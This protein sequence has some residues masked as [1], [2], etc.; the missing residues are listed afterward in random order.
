MPLYY[1]KSHRILIVLTGLLN[2][3][4]AIADTAHQ[5]QD[6]TVTATKTGATPLQITPITITTFDADLL[7][8]EG[9]NNIT[10]LRTMVP[11][12]SFSQV[13]TRGQLFIRGVGTNNVYPGSD[14]SSTVH[15]D[16]VYMARPF[17]LFSDL[18][19]DTESIEILRGPQGTLYGM[20]SIGG[21]V[22][23]KTTIPTQE[24]KSTA[25]VD[26]ATFNTVKT[27]ANI[28][29]GITDELAAGLSWFYAGSDGYV[30]NISPFGED[31]LNYYDD[32]GFKGTINWSLSDNIDVIMRANIIESDTSGVAYKPTY[33]TNTGMPVTTL[34]FGIEGETF[35]EK[36]SD[37]YTLNI[38]NDI[39]NDQR[40]HG[41]STT[42]NWDI[43]KTIQ[44]TSITAQSRLQ[45]EF[46]QDVDGTEYDELYVRITDYQEQ[47][48]QEFN[49][50]GKSDRLSWV[51]GLFY[52]HERN[53][54]NNNLGINAAGR[55]LHAQGLLPFPDFHTIV[56]N[57][58]VSND[59]YAAFFQNNYLIDESWSLTSGIRY[60]HVKKRIT[61]SQYDLSEDITL[62]GFSVDN[63]NS[64]N[65][66]TPKLSIEYLFNDD[67]F[68]YSTISR[69]FK[70]G[71]YNSTAGYQ[72]AFDPEF[73]NA[74]EIGL[75][76]QL[77]DNHLRFNSSLFY[78]D[79]K[80][81]QVQAFRLAGSPPTPS[82]VV[83]NAPKT[84]IQG[85]EIETNW[86]TNSHWQWD[87]AFSWLDGQYK[88]FTNT[89]TGAPTEEINVKGNQI[90]SSPKFTISLTG[91]YYQPIQY[92]EI[93]YLLQYYWQDKE[94][95]TTLNDPGIKQDSYHIVNAS[96]GFSS[97]DEQWNIIAY[98]NNLTN[99]EYT[100]GAF[101][102]S[103]LGVAKVITPPRT[104]G[105]RII[106]HY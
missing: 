60:T 72:A 100:V 41:F 69:G 104:V 67:I 77:F 27:A 53:G 87:T 93:H 71:G 103:S 11:N 74:Y 73:I 38:P 12:V 47:I 10:D 6:I 64:W 19:L 52:F 32:Y 80:D 29:G 49:L 21:T 106:Y 7:T 44:F 24:F 34:Q 36:I 26:Y 45:D 57:M 51:G 85:M 15:I 65:A 79:Y 102:S 78:N 30:D 23:I 92:G 20:N 5:L 66:W 18:F 48:N 76:S 33:I 86:V 43:S 95:Y 82:V 37:F 75:K 54:F 50:S 4:F 99:E 84:T 63:N 9:I 91:H 96:I 58:K 61:G 56:E 13:S 1:Q 83:E 31:P 46:I 68:A 105:L 3:S 97:H 59:T 62:G 2:I 8:N 88:Q 16:G 39:S 17:H 101:D 40:S 42:I 55:F 81:Y 22:N 14:P 98:I 70:A 94:Y 25:L 90:I 89:R 35:P 28:S